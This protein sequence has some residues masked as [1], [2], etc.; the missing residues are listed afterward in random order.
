[1]AG[2]FGPAEQVAYRAIF[3]AVR[4]AMPAPPPGGGP[5]ELSMPG[6]L[7]ELFAEAGL[8]VLESGEVNCPFSYPDFETFWRGNVAAG[9]MQGALKVVGEDVMKSALR[10]A[11]DAYR[12]DDG[13]IL[14][15]PNV[16]RYVVAAV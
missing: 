13:G 4:E 15:E 16:F 5:F 7:E 1:M 6:K 2:L 9:P 10:D 11:A 12:L 14:I 3:K 8:S